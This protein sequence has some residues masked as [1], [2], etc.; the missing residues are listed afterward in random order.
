MRIIYK[1][2]AHY[3]SKQTTLLFSDHIFNVFSQSYNARMLL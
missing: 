2:N 3:I 1:I